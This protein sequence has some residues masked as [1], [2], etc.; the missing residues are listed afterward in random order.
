VPNHVRAMSLRP[1]AIDA[2]QTLVAAIRSTMDPRPPALTGP[3]AGGTE[4][5]PHRVTRLR[6][7]PEVP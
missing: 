4:V 3:E 6:P 1:E 2:W 7:T 5:R